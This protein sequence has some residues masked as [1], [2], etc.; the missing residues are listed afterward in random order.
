MNFSNNFILFDMFKKW[1]RLHEKP[2]LANIKKLQ[3][4]FKADDFLANAHV[5]W[6]HT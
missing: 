5:K 6:A 3:R 2:L 4:H 1:N